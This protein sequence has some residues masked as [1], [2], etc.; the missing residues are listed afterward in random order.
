MTPHGSGTVGKTLGQ[1]GTS[2]GCSQ[3]SNDSGFKLQTLYQQGLFF[4]E[5]SNNQGQNFLKIL[6]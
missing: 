2:Y 1:K 5:D 3:L 4:A 6:L